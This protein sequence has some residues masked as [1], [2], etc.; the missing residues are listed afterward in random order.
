MRGKWLAIGEATSERED[1]E[2]HQQNYAIN[3]FTDMIK[4][5]MKEKTAWASI[6]VAN[7]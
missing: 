7:Q 4:T 6:N 3:T 1:E 5:I 2:M